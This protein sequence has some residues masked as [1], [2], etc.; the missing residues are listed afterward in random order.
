MAKFGI[1]VGDS[2]NIKGGSNRGE[3]GAS[4]GSGKFDRGTAKVT[5][6]FDHGCRTNK[7]YVH[8]NNISSKNND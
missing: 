8:N 1:K 5:K 7:G 3:G 6:V 2:I 4:S